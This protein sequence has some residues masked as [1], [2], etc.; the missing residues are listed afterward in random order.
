MVDIQTVLTYLTLIS[1]PV[2]VAYHIMTLNNTRKNQ[3]MQLEARQAQLYLFFASQMT[4]ETLMDYGYNVMHS[5]LKNLEDFNKWV[6]EQGSANQKSW[7]FMINFFENAGVLVRR[8]LLDIDMVATGFA[9]ITRRYWEKMKPVILEQRISWDQ[10][11]LASEFEYL[12]E[13]LMKYMEEHPEYK[14]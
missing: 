2:G 9:G 11:R 1:V 8:D 3:Q 5:D 4:S 10:P 14:T 12:Y 6:G 13:R 7:G